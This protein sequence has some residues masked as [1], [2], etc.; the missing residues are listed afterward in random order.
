MVVG[1]VSTFGGSGVLILHW[2]GSLWAERRPLFGCLLLT[3]SE[4]VGS[5]LTFTVKQAKGVRLDPT[6]GIASD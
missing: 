4:G 5:L 1:K 6:R 2:E 3:W